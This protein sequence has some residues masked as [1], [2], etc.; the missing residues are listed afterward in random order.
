MAFA[1]QMSLFF[2]LKGSKTAVIDAPSHKYR[3]KKINDSAASIIGSG[4]RG[5]ARGLRVELAS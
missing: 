3:E 1:H 5:W 2:L 4:G